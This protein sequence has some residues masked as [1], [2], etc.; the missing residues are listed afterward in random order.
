MAQA[1][2][3]TQD[4]QVARL[5]GA[6]ATRFELLSPQVVCGTRR[7]FRHVKMHTLGAVYADD[8]RIGEISM[9]SGG[10]GGDHVTALDPGIVPADQAALGRQAP[11]AGS[12]LFLGPFMNHYGHF[13]TESLSRCWLA[14]AGGTDA[15]DHY[16]F[17]PFLFNNGGI[18]V[19]EFHRHF[20]R[21]LGVPIERIHILREPALFEHVV[22]PQQLWV[23][24]SS[25][26]AAMADLYARL[27]ASRPQQPCVEKL[28]LSRKPPAASRFAATPA[29]ERL[30]A[31]RGFQIVYPEE[32][33]IAVQLDL[34]AGCRV[35]A[36]FSGSAMHSCLFASSGTL[37]IEVGDSRTRET[38]PPMQLICNALTQL[39]YLYIPYRETERGAPDED[40]IRNRLD[41]ALRPL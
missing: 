7:R 35:M 12:S 16:V 18:V 15:F 10:H 39:P 8:G 13:I 11:L 32:L 25:C 37:V 26:N 6:V 19:S 17:Y 31:D 36:G 30:F 24:N 38:T 27:R 14:V 41:A 9:R 3:T 29:V 28:F 40:D 20:F 2:I 34:Y 33:P 5:S 22:V 23:I 4:P 21:L 1:L